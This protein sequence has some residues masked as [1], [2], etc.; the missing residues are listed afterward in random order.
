MRAALSWSL[1]NSEERNFTWRIDATLLEK[2][3]CGLGCV[4]ASVVLH[5]DV[6]INI[7]LGEQEAFQRL[8]V[9][10]GAHNTVEDYQCSVAHPNDSPYKTL[11]RVALLILRCS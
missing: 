3:G 1:R 10:R 7:Y 5:K 6:T 4:R 2:L 8:L 11:G 9:T